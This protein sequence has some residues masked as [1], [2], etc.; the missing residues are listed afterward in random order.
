LNPIY[1]DLDRGDGVCIHFD[2]ATRLCKI[3]PHR[4]LKCNV[5]AMYH[6]YF[7][8]FMNINSYHQQNYGICKK[9]KET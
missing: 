1:A 3:Y 4:P 5:N 6:A 7:Y 9:L 2:E 8:Q